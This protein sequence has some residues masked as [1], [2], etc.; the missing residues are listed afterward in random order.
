MMQSAFDPH[1]P[2]AQGVLTLSWVMFAGAGLILLLVVAL[3]AYAALAPR[4]RRRWLA[5][6]PTI[7][8]GGIVFPV[9][10]LSALLVYGLLL[11]NDL[12]AAGRDALRIEITGEQWW[13]RVRYL[14]EAGQPLFE[15]ANELHLPAGRPV[16]L[17]L[18]SADVIHSFWAPNLAGKID[19]V[20]GRVNRLRLQA[21]EPGVLRGQCAEYC[22]GP[23]ALMAFY[24][25][26]E[27]PAAFDAWMANQRAPAEDPRDPSLA[28]GRERFMSA[29]CLAC[30]TI[31]GTPA[32]GSHGPDLTHVGS[33]VSIGAGNFPN[34]AGTLAVW[35]ADSQHLK[36]GNHMPPFAASLG[37]DLLAVAG[38]LE[39]L[40]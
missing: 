37:A 33:R 21:D 32:F 34:N 15:T 36:P 30:H 29:G 17:L 40:K 7:V 35:I 5:G 13:W 22:G 6:A 12:I 1:G 24:V 39:S 23:H 2:G 27:A 9:V 38:Y 10:T 28:Q 26:V 8:A 19:L 18:K 3:T 11:G 25:V 4:S 20:P 31:R 16:E 14:D